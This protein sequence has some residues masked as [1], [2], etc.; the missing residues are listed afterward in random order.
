MKPIYLPENND[1]GDL[2]NQAIYQS[3]S[4][5][6]AVDRPAL[7]FRTIA[8]TPGALAWCWRRIGPLY[9]HGL[10]QEAGWRIG[11]ALKLPSGLGISPEALSLVN[12]GPCEQLKVVRA[13]EAYNRVNPCNLIAIGVLIHALNKSGDTPLHPKIPLSQQQ[14]MPPEPIIPVTTMVEPEHISPDISR[15]ISQLSLDQSNNDQPVLVPS[16][17]RHLANVPGFLALAS[18]LLRPL[19]QQGQ[20]HELVNQVR[21][22][23]LQESGRLFMMFTAQSADAPNHPEH[24]TDIF[25]RFSWKIPEMIVVGEILRRSLPT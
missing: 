19:L 14:W 9:E 4:R 3:I 13:L 10:V 12:I 23:A 1:E 20:I 2:E 25:E 18:I 15:L 11:P 8:A 24:L 7:V 16:L 21:E 6:T 22:Q 17:Y 5:L